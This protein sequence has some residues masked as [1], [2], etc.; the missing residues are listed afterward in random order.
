MN[1]FFLADGVNE[2]QTKLMKKQILHKG[3]RVFKNSYNFAIKLG[4]YKL[5]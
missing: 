3:I 2:G 1:V 4:S 5:R